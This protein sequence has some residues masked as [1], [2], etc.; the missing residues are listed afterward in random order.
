MDICSPASDFLL[1]TF[2]PGTSLSFHLKRT[3]VEKG[4]HGAV[5]DF[6]KGENMLRT[7]HGTANAVG[8]GAS[9]CCNQNSRE[10]YCRIAELS[11]L[12]NRISLQK[13]KSYNFLPQLHVKWTRHKAAAWLWFL[14]WCHSSHHQSKA[15]SDTSH[16][17]PCSFSS[18]HLRYLQL[19]F[20]FL[21]HQ[22]E[23]PVFVY[24][25]LFLTSNSSVLLCQ[26]LHTSSPLLSF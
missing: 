26:V 3:R 13:N 17:D 15:F 19:H 22:E 25:S 6:P 5:L 10:I 24:H 2:K 18:L 12:S 20:L 16:W 14:S 23:D 7:I 9:Q 8:V 1:T 21:N 11:L 4:K